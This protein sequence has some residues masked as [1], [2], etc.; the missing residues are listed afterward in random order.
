MV[1]PPHSQ[2]AANRGSLSARQ[3]QDIRN[4]TLI[5]NETG[6]TLIMHGVKIV[7]AIFESKRLKRQRRATVDEVEQIQCICILSSSKGPFLVPL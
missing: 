7:C 4:L 5:A 2:P 1:P 6:A 3:L